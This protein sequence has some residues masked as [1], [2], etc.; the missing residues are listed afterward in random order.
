M[1]KLATPVQYEPSLDG[2]NT[3]RPLQLA[4]E[5]KTVIPYPVLCKNPPSIDKPAVGM[6]A[7]C[8]Q[9][10]ALLKSVPVWANRIFEDDFE[11]SEREPN[12]HYVFPTKVKYVFALLDMGGH[13]GAVHWT[14]SSYTQ[15]YRLIATDKYTSIIFM[16]KD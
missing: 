2:L 6:F 12:V 9:Q 14:D 4:D 5:V 15:E 11:L 8:S 13:S 1:P 10:G 16:G 7:R 3:I